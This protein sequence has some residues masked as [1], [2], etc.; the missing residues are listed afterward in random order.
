MFGEMEHQHR[1]VTDQCI[2]IRHLCGTAVHHKHVS[3][4]VTAR[5]GTIHPLGIVSRIQDAMTPARVTNAVKFYK[6]LLDG[7]WL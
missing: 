2:V 7:R 6:D 3:M 1:R 5:V 4:Y